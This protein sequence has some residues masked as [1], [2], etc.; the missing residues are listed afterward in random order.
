L[1]FDPT[2]LKGELSDRLDAL[3]WQIVT[4]GE[5]TDDD[6]KEPLFILAAA[7]R[8]SEDAKMIYHVAPVR[9]ISTI[10]HDGLL[11]SD[12]AR[13]LTQYPDTLGKIHGSLELI[14]QPGVC[15]GA[16]LWVKNFEDRYSE[17]FGILAVDLTELPRGARVYRDTHSHWGVVIDRIER[18]LPNKLRDVSIL[19]NL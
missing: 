5:R 14:N 4:T 1:D 13:S 18:I 8:L 3:G 7:P 6:G 10:L 15:D 16:T 17:P 19:N 12:E 11:P 9:V 2:S